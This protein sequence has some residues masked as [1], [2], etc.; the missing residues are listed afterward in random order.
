VIDENWGHRSTE[1]EPRWER[2]AR[3][4]AHRPWF[5][6][7]KPWVV[8]Q[9]WRDLVFAHW[10]VAPDAVRALL[11]VGLEL[12]TFED[13]AWIGVVPFR[14]S[15]IAPRGAPRR[16]HLAFPELNVRTYVTAE[17]KPGVWFFSLDAASLLAVIGAR[18]GFHLP[19]FWARMG[20][21][22]QVQGPV[23]EG[24]GWISFDSHRRQPSEVPGEFIA[25]Y[26]PTGAVFQSRRGSLEEWLT[27]RY[28]LYAADRKGQLYR[29]EIHHA[30]WP[31]QV[32]E[33]DIAVNRMVGSAID[34]SGPPLL[35]FARALDVLT[36][37]PE[38]VSR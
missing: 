9:S 12:D 18:I 28:C 10:A 20:L 19:Y 21:H 23:D 8:A 1:G 31:L 3:E 29:T 7:K 24:S 14:I 15:Y 34:L 16:W 13:G 27:A 32:A 4:V 22:A 17:G 38:R 26:R 30:P 6:P 35:H 37:P 5:P 2:I 25:R 33:A 36:W 11:P